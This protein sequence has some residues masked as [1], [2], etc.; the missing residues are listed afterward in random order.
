MYEKMYQYYVKT[1]S[2]RRESVPKSQGEEELK[3]GGG[4]KAN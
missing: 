1:V 4:G 2:I 3:K